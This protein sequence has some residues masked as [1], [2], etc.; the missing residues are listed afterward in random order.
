MNF[1][2]SQFDGNQ[3]SAPEI[4]DLN[5]LFTVPVPGETTRGS[6]PWIYTGPNPSFIAGSDGYTFAFWI[7]PQ[8]RLFASRVRNLNF[9]HFAAWETGGVVGEQAASFAVAVDALGEWHLAYMRTIGDPLHPAGIYYTHSRNGGMGW[10]LPV[11][12]YQ[13]AYLGHLGVGEASLS[14]ATAETD[15]AQHVYVAWDNRPRKQ[16]FLAHSADGGKSWDRDK[17]MLIAGPAPDAGLA[18]PLNIQVG[19]NQNNVV[20]VWQNGHTTNGT[21]PTCSQIYRSSSD[22]GTTW[23]E[24]QPMIENLLSCSLS[25]RFV[26][27]LPNGSD[28]PLYF[29]TETKSQAFLTAWNGRQWSQSQEQPTLS[30]FEEPEIYTQVTF[31]C[32]QGALLG[33]QLFVIG[34]DQAEGGDIWVTSRD[35]GSDTSW[36]Q[37]PVWSQPSPVTTDNY[38]M[39]AV[40]LLATD[41][42]YFHVFFNQQQDRAVYYTYSNGEF[43][44]RVAQVLQVPEGDFVVRATETGVGD[45][46]F[47]IAASNKGT[48]YYSRATSGD[49]A[50]ESSWSPPARLE[51]GHNGE[52]G[53][54]D[55]A[56]DASGTL[57]LAY[58]VPV[59]NDRGIYLVQ[60]KDQ[61]ATWSEPIQVFNGAAAGF[62]I[63]GAPTL[64]ISENDSLQLIWKKQ[65]IQGDGVAQSD[66]LYYSRSDDG[67]HTFSDAA[68]VVKEP[69]AWQEILTD[70]QGNVHVLWQPQDTHTTVWD[71]VS[72]DR[73]TTWQY[74]QG[75]PD[76][77]SPVAALTDVAGR[78]HLVGVGSDAL[79]HWLWDSGRWQSEAVLKSSFFSQKDS[80][81]EL[82][83]AAINKQ[84]KMMVVLAQRTGDAELAQVALHYSSSEL[85]LP[86][87]QTTVQKT[88]TKAAAT[89]T[90]TPA[91]ST[92]APMLT[93]TTT[94]DNPAATQTGQNSGSISPLTM[95]LFPV[96]LLLLSVLG[97]VIWRVARAKDR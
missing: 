24:P 53:S 88:P 92:P 1:V 50:T 58:S 67:G 81:V 7:T 96:G 39:E 32:H 76:T 36:F 82:L 5:R 26:T 49:A 87:V 22:A 13:S 42:G 73:G 38:K 51:V 55:L 35:L 68:P 25:N 27:G 47:L 95:A 75:L 85:E 77:G 45:K 30:G 71:Q 33:T 57:Y 79:G 59:N 28:S 80:P 61:G 16:V 4:T 48:L 18:G 41:D 69:V 46:L 3:W 62:D 29:L 12:L 11:L 78:L 8:R 97:I 74:P 70:G 93:P 44:S 91:T 86:S 83:A 64:I 2:Y 66:A 15:G 54:A 72:V 31:G 17:S 23:G 52:I 9:Q 43:W 65:S 10:A 19:A 14:V 56:Q 6:Q 84:G 60:S 21:L 90:R 63:V 37:P 40:D 34:C 89:P 94:D 20:L